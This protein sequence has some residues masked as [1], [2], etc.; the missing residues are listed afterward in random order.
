[1]ALSYSFVNKIMQ[2]VISLLLLFVLLVLYG[3]VNQVIDKGLFNYYFI[4]IKKVCSIV[5][6]SYGAIFFFNLKLW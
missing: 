6:P 1:M 2:D 3:L 5:A 4:I